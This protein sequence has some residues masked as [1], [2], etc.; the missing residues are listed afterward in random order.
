MSS[1][2]AKLILN[3][4]GATLGLIGLAFVVVQLYKYYEE[5]SAIRMGTWGFVSIFTLSVLYGL[6]NILMVIA[7][8]CIL[9]SLSLNP[10]FGWSI[11]AYSTSQLGKYIPG[12]IFQFAGRQA[13]GMAAGLDGIKL[14][15]STLLE[16]LIIGTCGAGFAVLFYS[17]T[18]SA[19]FRIPIALLGLV[20]LTLAF[21]YWRVDRYLSIAAIVQICFLALSGVI[22]VGCYHTIAGQTVTTEIVFML[23]TA[24]VV[25]WLIGL[26]TPGAPAGLGVREAV[27]L[28]LLSGI[29]AG[30]SI[31]L[32]VLIGR[33]VT[34]I[35][36][37]LFFLSSFLFNRNWPQLGASDGA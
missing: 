15:K 31:L 34:V 9:R 2:R 20:S 32:A 23:A 7:W 36:D 12:N 5:I 13:L 11:W 17:Y 3:I 26:I 37:V 4:A 10:R 18:I 24:Y 8:H 29:A 35:G 25:A 28:S 16:L 30:P 33:I 14:A 27:L 1:S 6:S 22:F 19:D 21:C